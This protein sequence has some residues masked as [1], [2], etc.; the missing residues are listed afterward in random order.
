MDV[1]DVWGVQWPC[2]HMH[3]VE[4]GRGF[5]GFKIWN[6]IWS[7]KKKKGVNDQQTNSKKL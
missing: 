4:G 6:Q 3:Y 7:H 2:K 5:G 1:V